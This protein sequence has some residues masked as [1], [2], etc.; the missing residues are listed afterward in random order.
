MIRYHA[1]SFLIFSVFS[2]HTWAQNTS[3]RFVPETYTLG[4]VEQRS[5]NHIILKGANTTSKDI[6]V[7]TAMSQNTGASNFKYP[8]KIQAGAAFSIEFDLN[9]AHMDGKF[10]HNIVVIDTSGAYY[11]ASVEGEVRSP[12]FF[13]EKLFD[14]GYYKTKDKREW[15]FYVWSHDKKTLPD[16]SLSSLSSKDFSIQSKPVMLNIDKLENIQEGGKVPAL[17]VTLKTKGIP[18]EGLSLKQKSLRHFVEFKSKNY[19][20]ATPEVLIIGYWK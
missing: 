14:A 11:T 6:I 3:L 17:K 16:L 15:T 7:E 18:R 2:M 12:L 13:S 1:L 9:T 8:S 5:V 19:P 10:I 20:K 4:V